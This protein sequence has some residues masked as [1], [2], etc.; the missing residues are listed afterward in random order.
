MSVQFDKMIQLYNV[1]SNT[2]TV[3]VIHSLYSNTVYK[4]E[5]GVSNIIIYQHLKLYLN[6]VGENESY[7]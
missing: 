3:I 2:N 4:L 5:L 7:M 6:T 1:L